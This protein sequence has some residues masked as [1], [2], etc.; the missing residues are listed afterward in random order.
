MAA[1]VATILAATAA[2]VWAKG[3]YGGRAGIAARRALLFV[4]YVVLPPATFFNLARV[5]VNADIGF[6]VVLGIV[7]LAAATL[8]AWWIG[9]RVLHLGRP[10]IG[11]MLCCTLV[12]NTGYLG[13][14]L[15]AA[16]LGFDRLSE[17]VVYDI[18]VSSPALLLGA[19]SVGA[20]FGERAGERPRQRVAAFFTRN[21]PLYAALLALIAPEALAPDV[22]V[23]ASRVAIVAILPLGFFAV[24]AALAEEAD[25][26]AIPVPPP[27]D[28]P[29][30]AIVAIR[31]LVAPGLLY[32]LALALIELPDTYLLLAAMP[33]GINTMIVTHAYGLDL[34]ISAGAVA[35]STAIAVAAIVP[36]SIIA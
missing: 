19:F 34:R 7:A 23:E 26:G 33:C 4:L 8:V 35:W 9:A 30:A 15:V 14:P 5:E 6:G 36:L 28:A 21:P 29:V 25:E 22:L 20:A 10:A 1:I 32:L 3:R 13:Y 16:L 17:A 2:G 12:A 18:L 27:L 31:L 24:G 11:S